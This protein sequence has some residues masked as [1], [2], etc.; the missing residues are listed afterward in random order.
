M[1]DQIAQTTSTAASSSAQGVAIPSTYNDFPIV[2]SPNQSQDG[3]PEGP[4]SAS[5][6]S[7][8]AEP[9]LG[10]PEESGQ[11]SFNNL[12]AELE[13]ASEQEVDNQGS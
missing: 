2:Q 10:L 9:D 7:N 4:S 8:P 5:L 13:V 12:V 3:I 11:M 1:G 6:D